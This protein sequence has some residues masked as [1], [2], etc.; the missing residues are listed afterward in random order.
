MNQSKLVS[1]AAGRFFAIFAAA[2]LLGF[3][4]VGDLRTAHAGDNNSQTAD[5]D[6][7]LTAVHQLTSYNGDPITRAEHIAA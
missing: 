7:L 3:N 1:V 5:V 6:L 4:P 2:G